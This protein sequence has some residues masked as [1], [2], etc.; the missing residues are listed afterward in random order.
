MLVHI[1]KTVGASK[2]GFSPALT[3]IGDNTYGPH[4]LPLVGNLF[5]IGPK[6]HESL[7]KL[8]NKHGPRMNI[9][10]GSVTSVVASSPAMAREI[11]HKNDGACSGGPMADATTRLVEYNHMVL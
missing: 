7:A 11:L 2:L 5:E 1:P 10:L 6:P 9:H 3:H 8:A 4:G